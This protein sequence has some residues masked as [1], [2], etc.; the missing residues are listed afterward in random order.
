MRNLLVLLLVVA[1]VPAKA[2]TP[3]S[4]AASGSV[5]APS[6]RNADYQLGAQDTLKVTVFDEPTLTGSFRIDA[7]GSFAYPLLERVKAAG[8]TTADVRTEIQKRL[9]EF[10]QRPQVTVEVD[11]FRARKVS[12]VGQ[13]RS[14]GP[15]TLIGQ[16]TVLEALAQAGYM[17]ADAGSEIQV[18]HQP[19]AGAARGATTRIA[20]ADLQANRGDANIVLREGDMV[21]VDRAQKFTVSGLVRS[22]NQYVWERDMT[23]RVA[24]ALAGGV[25]EKGS[26]RGIL[27]Y[28]NV[29]GKKER[30]NIGLDD[31]VEPN[32]IL[33]IRQRRL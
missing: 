29:S 17:T 27:V 20:I 11:Q 7:D 33:E 31:P 18:L 25:T 32:D 19:D 15:I 1:A 16:M 28:R 8:R 13:V 10:V 5:G 2:Q 12:V 22:P 3:P 30:R 4:A 26:T 6:E 21:I 14:P 23:V 9:A 24:I